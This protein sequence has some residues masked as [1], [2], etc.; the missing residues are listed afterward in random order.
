MLQSYA[1][2]LMPCL[3]SW[4]VL[5]TGSA[6]ALLSFLHWALLT[7]TTVPPFWSPAA[8]FYTVSF[9]MHAGIA[10]LHSACWGSLSGFAL[11]YWDSLSGFAVACW[12]SM[13][14]FPGL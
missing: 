6:P 4:S 8:P 7:P 1:S 2:C 5:V 14:G 12:D 3:T 9:A 10:C 11:A 13:S